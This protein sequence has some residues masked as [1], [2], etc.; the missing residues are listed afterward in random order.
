MQPP[1]F[2]A[3][4]FLLYCQQDFSNNN[5]WV[6]GIEYRWLL[7]RTNKQIRSIYQYTVLLTVCPIKL[8]VH[9]DVLCSTNYLMNCD[10]FKQYYWMLMLWI[11]KQDKQRNKWLDFSVR[12]YFSLSVLSC[13]LFTVVCGLPQCICTWM[14][15]G[16]LGS[17]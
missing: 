1:T 8:T 9:D 3:T 7:A 10:Y 11:Q 12:A 16:Q 4:T 14:S 13:T 5:N 15:S 2:I 17:I 6:I